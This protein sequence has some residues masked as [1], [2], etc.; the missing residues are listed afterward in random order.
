M[1]HEYQFFFHHICISWQIPSILSCLT[2]SLSEVVRCSSIL[3]QE[4]CFPSNI[5]TSSPT[6]SLSSFLSRAPKQFTIYFSL[7]TSF[8]TP[9]V[10]TSPQINQHACPTR[11]HPRNLPRYDRRRLR[12]H[13][14]HN[15]RRLPGHARHHWRWLHRHEG[16]HWWRMHRYARNDRRRLHCHVNAPGGYSPH[17]HGFA[18]TSH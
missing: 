10:F 12:S 18:R 7:Q 13:A 2:G 6:S 15:R 3:V 5:N 4:L 1:H 8:K 14:R 11:E 17:G 16:N 9:Q